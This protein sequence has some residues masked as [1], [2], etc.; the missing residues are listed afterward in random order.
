[1]S[2]LKPTDA[3]KFEKLFEMGSGYVLDFTDARFH[4][5]IQQITG[6]DIYTPKY[7]TYGGSKAKR[8]RAFWAK[9]NDPL[10]GKLTLE[11]L[12]YWR[13]I[14]MLSDSG[15]TDPQDAL[16]KECLGIAHRLSSGTQSQAASPAAV[17]SES[18]FLK[19]NYGE[20]S[21]QTLKLESGLICILD[22]RIEEIRKSLQAKASLSVIFLCGSTLEGILLGTATQNPQYFN[23]SPASPKNKETGKVLE[24]HQWSLNDLINVAHQL[25]FLGLD[26]K[27][28][29]HALRDF[30]NYIHPYQ[31]WRS[32]FNPDEH[33]AL[34]CWQ[35][36][37]A[38][39]HDLSGKGNP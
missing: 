35:V 11:L 15:I 33:T 26:V 24:F 16:Y 14:K 17:K 29:S 30:R 9:E 38:A 37:K 21:L 34:I 25:A 13:T 39:V 32:G 31:Q 20:I 27:Q 1:M 7:N 10:V 2:N 8:L 3:L 18:D 5:F 6:M 36:L 4:Q 28:F 19:H 23:E 22:Q 12:E